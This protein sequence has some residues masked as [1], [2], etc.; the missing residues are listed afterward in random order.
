MLLAHFFR[1]R[2]L[3]HEGRVRDV[4][5]AYREERRFRLR[6]ILE[7][8]R[9]TVH[10]VVNSPRVRGAVS[11]QW[12]LSARMEEERAVEG[13]IAYLEYVE[14]VSKGALPERMRPR[15]SLFSL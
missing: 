2:S 7:A 5:S 9:W 10:D 13:Y 14:A 1:P 6:R 4:A 12:R 11:E 3:P 8:G 15:P